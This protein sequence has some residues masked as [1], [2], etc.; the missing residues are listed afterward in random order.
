MT[1]RIK[2]AF[3]PSE[4]T[5]SMIFTPSPRPIHSFITQKLIISDNVDFQRSKIIKRIL[6]LE[7]NSK[8]VR[9]IP[10]DKGIPLVHFSSKKHT[11]KIKLSLGA[12]LKLKIIRLFLKRQPALTELTID[13]FGIKPVPVN[14]LPAFCKELSKFAHL[15]KIRIK[16]C[17]GLWYLNNPTSH[18][19]NRKSSQ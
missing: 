1:Q 3:Q 14:A 5:S 16:F 8:F 15:T 7:E 19:F 10:S 17:S 18:F 12:T 6:A 4:P 11:R 9:D 2:Q 13:L